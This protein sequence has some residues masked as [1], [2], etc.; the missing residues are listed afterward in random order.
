MRR[1]SSQPWLQRYSRPLIGA[2]ATAGAI[3]TAYL[4]YLRFTSSTCPTKTCAVLESRYATVFGQPLAL[5]GLLAYI[6]MI[7]FALL[8][9]L[10]S[11]ET[12][13]VLRRNLEEQT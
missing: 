13:K 2:I 7:V 11:S 6:G 5:F 4:T 12:Q 3:N 8:P 1:T 9:L 10:I